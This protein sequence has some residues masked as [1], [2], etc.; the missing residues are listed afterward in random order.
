MEI[1]LKE[2]DSGIGRGSLM[3]VECLE[4]RYF[5]TSRQD[6]NCPVPSDIRGWGER[7][8]FI[9]T[10]AGEFYWAPLPLGDVP[11]IASNDLTKYDF[12]SFEETA[13]RR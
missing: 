8:I 13:D 7:G 6:G 12:V 9:H 4:V 1:I 3:R 2:P 10:L 11:D 5:L